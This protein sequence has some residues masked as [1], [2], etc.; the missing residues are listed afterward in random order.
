MNITVQ[1][2]ENLYFSFKDTDDKKYF[3]ERDSSEYNIIQRDRNYCR[4]VG[5]FPKVNVLAIEITYEKM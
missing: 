3:V 5:Y 4:C 2:K 1:T